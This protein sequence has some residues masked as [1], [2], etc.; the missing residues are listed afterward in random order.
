MI[1]LWIR[2]EH[3][4]NEKGFMFESVFYRNGV[5]T[6]LNTIE[7]HHKDCDCPECETRWTTALAADIDR[8][9]VWV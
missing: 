9:D 6:N 7:I 1:V 2:G 5:P 3:Q 8:L 4:E